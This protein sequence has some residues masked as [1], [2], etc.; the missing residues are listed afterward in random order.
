MTS[1]LKGAD[2][3]VYQACR[4]LRLQPSLQMIY[5]DNESRGDVGIMLDQIAQDPYYHCEISTYEGTLVE[6]MG[7]VPVNKT[8]STSL[9][10][11]FWVAEAGREGEYLGLPIQWAKSVGGH[12]CRVWE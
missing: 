6:E 1:Y 4:E 11:S 3:H 10:D 9:E 7:G 8:E 5:D 12:H 2:A